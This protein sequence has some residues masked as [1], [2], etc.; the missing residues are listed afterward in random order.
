MQTKKSNLNVGA[1]LLF[2]LFAIC[3]IAKE[4]VLFTESG[5]SDYVFRTGKAGAQYV[6]SVLPYLFF[7][8]L[9][10]LFLARAKNI[11]IPLT[12][13]VIAVVSILPFI[14][15]VLPDLIDDKSSS[16]WSN[17]L[18]QIVSI[19][20]YVFAAGVSA[21]CIGRKSGDDGKAVESWPVPGAMSFILG[22]SGFAVAADGLGDQIETIGDYF[23]NGIPKGGVN[24]ILALVLLFFVCFFIPLALVLGCKWLAK[25]PGKVGAAYPVT[26]NGPFV[27]N[28]NPAYNAPAPTFAPPAPVYTAP[29]QNFVPQP[30]PAP[31]PQPEPVA[32]RK[33]IGYDPMTGAPIYEEV[34]EK[35]EEAVPQFEQAAEKVEEAVPQFEQAAEKVDEAVPQFEQAAEKI[36]EVAEKIEE[37]APSFDEAAGKIEDLTDNAEN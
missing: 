11:L 30:A 8:I 33:P 32:E 5:Y 14:I 28:T 24:G 17:V 36:E 35:V 25:D 20:P 37:A 27:P 16:L 18:T 6:L 22:L 3:G 21:K 12:F 2:L 4:V 19:L 1:G 29:A 10:F 15:W 23:E 34:A 13:I 9:G 26:N 7:L 31:A